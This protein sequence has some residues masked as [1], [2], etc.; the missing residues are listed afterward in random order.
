MNQIYT[1]EKFII[2]FTDVS[3]LGNASTATKSGCSKFEKH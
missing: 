3:K 1:Y 2:C